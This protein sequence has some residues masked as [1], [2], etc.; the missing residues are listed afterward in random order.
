MGNSRTCMI[1]TISPSSGNAENTLNTLRYADRVK[2]MKADSPPVAN[3]PTDIR[4][5]DEG[6]L[7][8]EEEEPEEFTANEDDEEPQR[9]EYEDEDERQS[10]AEASDES[11]GLDL[12]E[13]FPPEALQSL[14]SDDE[15]ETLVQRNGSQRDK[16]H[17]PRRPGG[18]VQHTPSSKSMEAAASRAVAVEPPKVVAPE[19]PAPATPGGTIRSRFSILPLFARQ[20]PA[21]PAKAV[22][23]AAVAPAPSESI[24]APAPAAPVP[25]PVPPKDSHSTPT[26]SVSSSAVRPAPVTRSPAPAAPSTAAGGLVTGSPA[27]ALKGGA[28]PGKLRSPGSNS[29]LFNNKSNTLTTKTASPFRLAPRMSA[30]PRMS[31]DDEPSPSSGGSSDGTKVTDYEELV[32]SHRQFIRET[33]EIARLESRILA[34][35]TIR[36]NKSGGRDVVSLMGKDGQPVV[37]DRA[38]DFEQYARELDAVLEKKVEAIAEFRA[39]LRAVA[40]GPAM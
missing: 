15:N 14:S 6:D 23:T 18:R 24:S 16:A 22:G 33:A 32:R 34:N 39:R 21:S 3:E 4:E 30:Q 37:S 27:R 1:A 36:L 17:T 20:T 35:F 40:A 9:D 19:P 2:E 26:R 29:G 5:E 25:A 12:N 13:E 10:G 38:S 28:S 8:D 7:A 31:T 11:I